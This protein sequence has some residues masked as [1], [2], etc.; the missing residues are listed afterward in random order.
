MKTY[1]RYVCEV[2]GTEYGKCTDAYKCEAKC[3]NLTYG[4]YE[5]YTKLLREEERA[6]R[7]LESIFNNDTR[8]RC[9]DAVRAVIAFKNAYHICD[10]R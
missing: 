6:F 3:L 9:D 1:V 7:I 10:S 4:Q 8:K 2:C 5:C